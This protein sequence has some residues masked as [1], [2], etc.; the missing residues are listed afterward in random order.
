MTIHCR[1]YDTFSNAFKA[2][3]IYPYT[4]DKIKSPLCYIF[5]YFRIL[6]RHT[7]NRESKCTT[8][9]LLRKS[10]EKRSLDISA[11]LKGTKRKKKYV[12]TTIEKNFIF[13]YKFNFWYLFFSFLLK[14][15]YKN[16]LDEKIVYPRTSFI[17]FHNYCIKDLIGTIVTQFNSITQISR[18]NDS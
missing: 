7:G 11:L 17:Y 10:I 12:P 9:I 4:R 16:L 18:V 8:I 1:T 14:R 3:R 5:M 13:N 15:V 2:I 6:R